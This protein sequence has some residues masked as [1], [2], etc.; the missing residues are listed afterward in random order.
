MQGGEGQ[1]DGGVCMWG[2]YKG[3]ADPERAL[4]AIKDIKQHSKNVFLIEN[5]QLLYIF[6]RGSLSQ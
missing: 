4:H 5:L 1:R 3:A 6:L 2:E